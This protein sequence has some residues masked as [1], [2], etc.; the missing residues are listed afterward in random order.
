M[1]HIPYITLMAR[2]EQKSQKQN[3]EQGGGRRPK[4][5]SL[6]GAM[7]VQGMAGDTAR[8]EFLG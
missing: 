5:K 8:G 6:H 7:W 4:H 1:Q 2:L 3:A